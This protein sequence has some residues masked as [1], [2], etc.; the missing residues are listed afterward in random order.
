MIAFRQQDILQMMFCL[1]LSI[2]SFKRLILPVLG[3]HTN[4]NEMVVMSSHQIF[5]E[6]GKRGRN[7]KSFLKKMHLPNNE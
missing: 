5:V 4:L 2:I 3:Q 1:H 7:R 6:I